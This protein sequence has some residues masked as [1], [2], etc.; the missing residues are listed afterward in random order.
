MESPQHVGDTTANS[1]LQHLSDTHLRLPRVWLTRVS[2]TLIGGTR[3]IQLA[4]SLQDSPASALTVLRRAHDLYVNVSQMLGVPMLLQAF[5]REQLD[6]FLSN[7]IALASEYAGLFDDLRASPP[8]LQGMWVPYDKAIALAARFDVYSVVKKLLLVDV[9]DFDKLPR[10]REHETGAAAAAGPGPGPVPGAGTDAADQKRPLEDGELLRPKKPAFVA[11]A[12]EDNANSP[13]ALPPLHFDDKDADLVASAKLR[14]SDIFKSDTKQPLLVADIELHFRSLVEGGDPQR[15]DVALDAL[16][17]TALHYAAALAAENLV[18]AFVKM[19]ICSPVRGDANGELP[20]AAAL[21]VTNAMEK[22]NFVAVLRDWLWPGVWLLDAR[23]RLFAHLLASHS[24]ARAARFYFNKIIEWMVAN[25]SRSQNLVRFLQ[26]V[27][28]QDA[29]TG[30]TAL[31]LAGEHEQKWLVH[32]LLELGASSSIANKAGVRASDFQL[33]KDVEA[34]RRAF[35]EN[36]DAPDAARS[37]L[38][39]LDVPAD[40]EYMLHL[41]RTAADFRD[42]TAPYPEVG[43]MEPLAETAAVKTEEVANGKDEGKESSGKILGSIQD[44]LRSTNSEYESVIRTKKLEVNNLNRELRDATITTANNRYIA[45][46]VYDKMSQM[47]TLKLQMSNISDKLQLLRKELP[48]GDDTM[49]NND[50]LV[51]FDADEPF[52]IRPIYDR[53]AK[54]EHIEPTQETLELLPSADILKA[55]LKAYHEVNAKL[56]R[57]LDGLLDYGVLTAKFKKVV[58]FCTGVDINEVDDLLDGLLEAVERQ[59]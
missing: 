9:H 32:L 52:I 13:Y 6:M 39:S 33:V 2:A 16:G 27:N 48:E 31:H 41:V 29:H 15:L 50:L 46:Q 21:Q 38:A 56:Q 57:D 43:V 10:D 34:L 55:R 24:N 49:L 18:A 26:M 1:I 4:V 58:S 20:L 35:V 30:S 36:S 53:V 8:P 25:P 42:K 22:G 23:G 44:L 45:R 51:K 17:K 37:L 19:Q 28:L 47:D 14:L 12:A 5:S 59:Q 7:E 3:Y 54:N 11:R 40:H